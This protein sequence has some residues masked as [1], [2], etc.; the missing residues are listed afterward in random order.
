[1]STL[2]RDEELKRIA[3]GVKVD[4]KRRLLLPKGYVGGDNIFHIYVNKFGQIV[5]DPQVNV[6]ASEAWLFENEPA[7]ASIDNGMREVKEG[8]TINR[9]SFANF[10]DEP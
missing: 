1:M 5:L 8:L 10:V 6:P 9:G 7:L 3:V 2:I 4:S